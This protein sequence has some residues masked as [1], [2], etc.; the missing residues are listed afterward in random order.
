V[1]GQQERLQRSRNRCQIYP[2]S[3]TV[4]S[5]TLNLQQNRRLASAKPLQRKKTFFHQTMMKIL[6]RQQRKRLF[7]RPFKCRVVLN[8]TRL[9]PVNKINKHRIATTHRT[10]LAKSKILGPLNRPKI[11]INIVNRNKHAKPTPGRLM[12]E[13]RSLLPVTKISQRKVF[14]RMKTSPSNLKN[15]LNPLHKLP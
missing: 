2:C 6:R 7:K 12:S 1:S 15:K 10:P 13:R 8:K 9:I 11:T 3:P 14:F 5:T 4:T